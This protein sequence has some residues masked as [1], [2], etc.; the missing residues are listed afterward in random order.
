MAGV[1]TIACPMCKQKLALQ[2]YV[3]AGSLVVCANPKCGTSLRVIKRHPVKVEMVAEH[4][5][6][7]VDYRPESYG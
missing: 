5:T 3:P 7:H 6:H 1:E 2:A 4:E